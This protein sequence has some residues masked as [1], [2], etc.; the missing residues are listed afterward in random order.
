[1]TMENE[2][3]ILEMMFPDK[4]RHATDIIE[5]DAFKFLLV[6][7]DGRKYIFDSVFE[8]INEFDYCHF[9]EMRD[10]TEL[11]WRERFAKKLTRKLVQQNLSQAI[12]SR[13]TGISRHSIANY[14]EGKTTPSFYNVA[15]IARTLG[16]SPSE[17]Y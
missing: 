2:L 14:L 16:C 5:L 17:L 3:R 15:K 4:Y 11:E 1:M 8:S 9:D 12:L 6:M 13:R 7:D 10:I